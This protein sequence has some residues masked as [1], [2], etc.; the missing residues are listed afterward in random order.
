MSIRNLLFWSPEK[1][2][3]KSEKMAKERERLIAECEWFAARASASMNEELP[4]EHQ[5]VGSQDNVE[6]SHMDTEYIKKQRGIIQS[7][8][9]GAID[10]INTLWDLEIEQ[11]NT[12]EN[13][14]GVIVSIGWSPE[15]LRVFLS[16]HK[17]ERLER[18]FSHKW[19]YLAQEII[20]DVSE[21]RIELKQLYFTKI[22]ELENQWHTV[23]SKVKKDIF[24]KIK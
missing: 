6:M 22:A 4:E 16:T 11:L 3:D 14:P 1:R 10:S 13:E 2:R 9:D 20:D 24:N 15:F 23:T 5:E 12:N 21:K 7:Y 19:L 8:Y 17:I 18:K